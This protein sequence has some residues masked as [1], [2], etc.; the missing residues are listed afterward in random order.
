MKTLFLIK[1]IITISRRKKKDITQ[2]LNERIQKSKE[3]TD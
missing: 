1:T 2:S 3:V